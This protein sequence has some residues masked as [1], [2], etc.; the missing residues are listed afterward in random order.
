MWVYSRQGQEILFSLLHASRYVLGLSS[1][2]FAV[3]QR[4]H[5]GVERRLRVKLSTRTHLLPRLW[6]N[7]AIH[8][9]RLKTSRSAQRKT[10]LTYHSNTE[11]NAY[12]WRRLIAFCLCQCVLVTSVTILMVSVGRM[13]FIYYRLYIKYVWGQIKYGENL[14]NV[15]KRGNIKCH[16]MRK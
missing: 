12:L 5:R 9:L 14:Q 15:I 2:L 4:L 16:K 1:L 11:E 10:S 3:Y 13:Q 7:G 6:I 8:P